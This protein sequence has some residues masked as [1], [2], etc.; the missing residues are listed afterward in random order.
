MVPNAHVCTHSDSVMAAVMCSCPWQTPKS[1]LALEHNVRVNKYMHGR[2]A[3]AGAVKVQPNW[4]C[5][6]RRSI[7]RARM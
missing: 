2:T 3:Q 5:Q 6:S 7:T 1:D 4:R